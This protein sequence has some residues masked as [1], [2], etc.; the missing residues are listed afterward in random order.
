MLSAGNDGN[1]KLIF[2]APYK[3][4]QPYSGIWTS[5]FWMFRIC[6]WMY[7]WSE[8][9]RKRLSSRHCRVSVYMPDEWKFFSSIIAASDSHIEH[10]NKFIN[11]IKC[12]TRNTFIPSLSIFLSTNPILSCD[13][14]NVNI[15]DAWVISTSRKT[16]FLLRLWIK[17]VWACPAECKTRNFAHIHIKKAANDVDSNEFLEF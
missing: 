14:R 1:T 7:E 9:N 8:G 15:S 11:A 17:R 12:C 13:K 2:F 6:N 4:G 3:N 16:C 5:L 10:S